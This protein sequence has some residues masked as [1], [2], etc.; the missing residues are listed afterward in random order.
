MPAGMNPLQHAGAYD[1]LVVGGKVSPGLMTIVSG[2]EKKNNWDIKASGGV[3]GG[4]ATFK[5]KHPIEKHKIKFTLWTPEQFTA[6]YAWVKLL[7][8]DP[9][10]RKDKALEVFNPILADVGIR[11]IVIESIGPQMHEG[12]GRFAYTITFLN[13][14]PPAPVKVATPNG[15]A[16]KFIEKGVPAPVALTAQERQIQQLMEQIRSEKP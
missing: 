12:G 14:K 6:W 16:G 8:Y 5:G 13:Y 10:K 9:T 15:T 3:A 11:A 7:D 2:C 4:T 1:V